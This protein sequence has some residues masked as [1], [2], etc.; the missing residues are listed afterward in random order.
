MHFGYYAFEVFQE[1]YRDARDHGW[2]IWP[3]REQAAPGEREVPALILARNLYGVDIDL[4][5]VQL[6]ALSLFMKARVAERGIDPDYR[7]PAY[8]VNLVSADARLANGELRQRFLAEYEDDPALQQVWRELFAEMEDIAQVGSL[9]RVEERLRQLLDRYQPQSLEREAM[10]PGGQG[11]LP[12]DTA[13]RQMSLAEAP[14]G[15]SWTPRRTVGEMLKHLREFA[16]DALEE[17]DVNAQLFAVEAEKTVGLLDVMLQNYD[18]LVMNP[19]YGDTTPRAKNWLRESFPDSF[20]DLYAAFVVRAM[21]LTGRIGFIGALTSRSFLYLSRLERFRRKLVEDLRIITILETDVGLLDDATVRPSA[22]VFNHDQVNVPTVFFDLKETTDWHPAFVR[23]LDELKPGS[24]PNCI[25]A[26]LQKEFLKLPNTSMAYWINDDLADLFIELPPFGTKGTE[27]DIEGTVVEIRQGLAT[28]GDSQFVRQFWEVPKRA[29]DKRW[30]WFAKGGSY[31]PY[32]YDLDLVLD[33]SDSAVKQLSCQGNKLPSKDYYFREGLTYPATSEKGLTVRYLKPGAAPSVKGS[34]IYFKD[35]KD[36]WWTLAVY[37]SRLFEGLM[38]VFTVDREHQVGMMSALPCK[39]PPDNLRKLLEDMALDMFASKAAWDTGNEI[40]SRFTKPWLL[41]LAQQGIAFTKGLGLGRVRDRLKHD[42]SLSSVN[43]P[44][45]LEC[46]Q[47]IEQGADARLQVLQ[48][49]IDEAVYDLYEISPADQ[50]LIERELGERPPELVWPQMEGKSRKEKNREHLRR[51][52]SYFVLEA[53]KAD[54]DG[55]LPLF[56]GTGEATVLERLR[57][58]LAAAFGEEAAFQLE[59]DAGQV[60]GR[61]VANWL[62]GQFIKWHTKL[63]NKRPIIWHLASP[64]NDFGL[65]LYY[66]KLDRDTLRKV[67]T[68]Y[69]RTARERAQAALH[70]ARERGD[71]AEVSDRERFL[72][73]LAVLDERL[74]AVINGDV[75][76]KPPKWA[77]GPYRNGLYDPVIDDGVKVNIMPLQKGEVLRYKRMV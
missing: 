53:L 3:N 50:A 60:M 36:I 45:L 34:G 18:I 5:A 7:A 29:I 43:L 37:N 24:I 64:R 65:L 19:P 61:P 4:R 11:E 17:A 9:L 13:P 54:E 8:R 35:R 1:I 41:Q 63:Y 49:E 72:D 21:E 39:Y 58:R 44:S 74:L 38:R 67:R 68:L 46:S 28:G 32:Y 10:R 15:E 71:E 77:A 31:S 33:W 76:S 26:T 2:P 62:D 42:A 27:E 30:V 16:R 55:I 70:R 52:L 23:A 25:F 59:D 57:E 6:A 20:Y 48:A 69:I 40:S 47:V 75:S 14:G 66:H 73:E 22:S 51:L 56:P 12:R